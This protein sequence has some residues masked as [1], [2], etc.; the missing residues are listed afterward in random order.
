M[1]YLFDK[2]HYIDRYDLL[3]IKECLDWEK[4]V[5]NRKLDSYKGKEFTKEQELHLKNFLTDLPLYFI[6]GENYSKKSETIRTWMDRDQREQDKYDNAIEPSNISCINCGGE[7]IATSKDLYN[8]TNEPL[9]VLFFFDCLNCKKRRGIFDTGEE[10]KSHEYLCPECKSQVKVTTSKNSGKVTRTTKC[11]SCSYKNVEVDDFEEWRKERDKERKND[12]ELLKEY[13]SKYCLTD[14]EGQEYI[15]SR[16][17]INNFHQMVGEQKRKDADPAYSKA[18]NLKKLSVIELEKL[19]SLT[20]EKQ[21]YV[22]LVLN[23]PEIGQ[24]VIVPFTVQ[25]AD[26][27]R[28]EYDSTHKLQRIIKDALIETNWRL[29]SEG[30]SYRLGYVYGRLKGYEREEDLA[31]LVRKP[32]SIQ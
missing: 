13:R 23:S 21:K 28:K 12:E 14:K 7:M 18:R 31:N 30:T 6:K 5:K 15:Q 27:S 17:S 9:K 16:T 11:V 32:H 20:L 29:M 4:R 25:D 24:Y 22:K 19:L 3:T 10:F 1:Q 26:N 2:Q 8:F